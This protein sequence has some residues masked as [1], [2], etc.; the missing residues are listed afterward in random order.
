MVTRLLHDSSFTL[1]KSDMPPALVSDVLDSN[2]SPALLAIFVEVG[3]SA[4]NILLSRSL[5]AG[6]G[7]VVWAMSVPQCGC[8]LIVTHHRCHRHRR[9]LLTRSQRGTCHPYLS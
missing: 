7:I 6:G 8:D 2:L 4:G 9:P 1:A 3:E 5:S